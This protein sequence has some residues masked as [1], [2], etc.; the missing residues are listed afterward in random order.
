MIRHDELQHKIAAM[1]NADAGDVYVVV[2]SD[3]RVSSL[4]AAE[5]I[6]RALD[7][8]V[9]AGKRLSFI[10]THYR[11]IELYLAS[12]CSRRSIHPRG[13]VALRGIGADFVF[14]RRLLDRARISVEVVRRQE[15]KGAAD[16]FVRE[17][18]DERQHEQY[19]TYLAAAETVLERELRRSY[20][21]T[22]RDI[23]ALRKS[24]LSADEA[25]SSGWADAVET[26]SGIKADL[27]AANTDVPDSS[28]EATPHPSKR[29]TR[30]RSELGG[31]GDT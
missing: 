24:V 11:E 12:R 23:V 20:R 21:R 3:S 16:G 26:W 27:E 9:A 15:F 4:A 28:L 8:L 22:E 1:L 14:F 30:R 18:F 29:F 5:P 13:S 7:K 19:R 2:C 10:A 6:A 25:V 31:F 17:A